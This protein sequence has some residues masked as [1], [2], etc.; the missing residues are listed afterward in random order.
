MINAVD[1]IHLLLLC[2]ARIFLDNCA[3]AEPMSSFGKQKESSL[4]FRSRANEKADKYL[5]VLFTRID[6]FIFAFAF[7]FGELISSHPNRFRMI[8]SRPF[9]TAS[10]LLLLKPSFACAPIEFI[11]EVYVDGKQLKS[12][13]GLGRAAIPLVAFDVLEVGLMWSWVWQ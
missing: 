11:L 12:D 2:C 6:Y 9:Q 5:E 13:V 8:P 3:L 4:Y 7:A 1:L 10:I